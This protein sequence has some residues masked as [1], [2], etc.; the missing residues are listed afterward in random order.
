MASRAMVVTP[1]RNNLL[2]TL[3]PTSRRIRSPRH[4][5]HTRSLAYT[6]HPIF[7][8]PVLP[9]ETMKNLY[10]ESRVITDPIMNS[11]I[12]WKQEYRWF[13]V[14]ASDLMFDALRDMFIDPTNADLSGTYGIAANDQAF[15]TAKGGVDWLKRCTQRVW[16]T[17]FSDE[18][19]VYADYDVA[20]VDASVNG[21]PFVQIKERFWLDSITD[22]DNMPLGT[23]PGT[24]TNINTLEALWASY[25]QLRALGFADMTY[26]DWLRSY[27]VDVPFKD[28]DK[29]EELAAFTDFQY[30][31]N[32]VD[33][34]TGIPASAVSWVFK[35]SAR[36]PKQFKEPGFVIGFSITRP[37]VY[38]GGIA[39]NLAAH[40]TRAW[41]WVP[42]YMNEAA[43]S[44]EPWTSLKKFAS[45]TGPLGDR[46]TAT[47]AYWIDMRDLLLHGDQLQNITA[48]N[49]V[50]ATVGAQHL[51][52]LPPG[53]DHHKY[54]YPSAADVKSF[55][56]DAAGTD[57]YIRQD[58]YANFSVL[59]HQV[60]YTQGNFAEA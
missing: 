37:K 2:T 11:I 3:P 48:F 59:G 30:P 31:S 12:G 19:D 14:K 45:D 38:Y 53:D 29:P 26:E 49:V 35:N 10:F 60:D 15:Y 42:N 34:A 36:D 5:W 39:G 20:A 54:K 8:A 57:F 22:E 16:E 56:V 13:Y 52:S 51:L 23:D 24:A 7:F 47:D 44:P 41:D 21:V 4:T 32:T 1:G 58:G 33:P 27:G 28:E 55:F 18:G 9:G 25:E 50:P 46:T 43:A 17:W 40:M 6:L